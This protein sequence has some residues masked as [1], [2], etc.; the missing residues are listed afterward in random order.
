MKVEFQYIQYFIISH[1]LFFGLKFC[2]YLLLIV[3]SRA[4][5]TQGVPHVQKRYNHK[6]PEAYRPRDY[7][8][9]QKRTRYYIQL[10]G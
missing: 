8:I 1:F 6:I 3:N 5:I 9:L 4:I 2:Y 10:N 7:R